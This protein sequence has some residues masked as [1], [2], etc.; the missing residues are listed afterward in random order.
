MG[1]SRITF[2]FVECRIRRM[3]YQLYRNSTNNPAT[4]TAIAAPTLTSADDYTPTPNVTYYYWVA[5][6]NSGNVASPKSAVETGFSDAIAPTVT[7]NSFQSQFGPPYV[8]FTFSKPVGASI[9]QSSLTLSNLDQPGGAVPTVTSL[10]YISASNT[11]TFSLSADFPDGNFR[12]TINGVT[13]VA[14]NALDGNNT[15][16]FYFLR[17]DASGDRVVNAMDFNALATHFGSANAGFSGGDF[18]FDGTVSTED[19]SDMATRWGTVL[20]APAPSQPITMALSP[21]AGASLFSSVSIGEKG[22]PLLVGDSS[23]ATS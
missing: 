19:F 2:S 13:D 14:G 6:Y 4:A 18:N 12:A 9:T 10:Q 15:G 7:G 5:S 23:S 17:G 11:A 21:T 3:A 1:C 22:D 16:D 8:S 20:A